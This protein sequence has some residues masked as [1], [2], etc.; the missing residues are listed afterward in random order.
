MTITDLPTQQVPLHVVRYGGMSEYLRFL[1]CIFTETVGYELTADNARINVKTPFAQLA[2]WD[3]P[4]CGTVRHDVVAA[5]LDKENAPSATRQL[6]R[7]ARQHQLFKLVMR[8]GGF[9]YRRHVFIWTDSPQQH[10]E[11]ASLA[12]DLGA[13][14]RRGNSSIRA[15][16]SI[17]RLNGR[18]LPDNPATYERDVEFILNNCYEPKWTPVGAPRSVAPIRRTSRAP[19]RADRGTPLGP[20]AQVLAQDGIQGSEGAF[21]LALSMYSGGRDRDEFLRTLQYMERHGKLRT[22]NPKHRG[23]YLK[24]WVRRI[25]VKVE[26]VA[27]TTKPV[28][29]VRSEQIAALADWAAARSWTGATGANTE[30]VWAA[31]VLRAAKLSSHTADGSVQVTAG[32]ASIATDAGVGLRAASTGLRQLQQLGVLRVLAKGGVRYDIGEDG[33]LQAQH[34][35]T[36]YALSV[37]VAPVD[38]YRADV[39]LRLPWGHDLFTY[40]GLGKRGLQMYRYLLLGGSTDDRQAAQDLGWHRLT[41]AR[42]RR[43]LTQAR[44]ISRRGMV[45][46]LQ[47]L[48]QQ[49]LQDQARRL[50][51]HGTI[52]RRIESWT[53][54]NQDAAHRMMD[55][56]AAWFR[57]HRRTL[58]SA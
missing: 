25:W 39:W 56:A 11:L 42:Y 28:G 29:S 53:Q 35:A 6:E 31:L 1:R 33:E 17:H 57:Q 24:S 54:R 58:S 46:A 18:S 52:K 20:T 41:V 32:V 4:F 37:P 43:K 40:R 45:T 12:S 34:L 36:I 47:D 9:N 23:R 15:P 7:Y 14:V 10:H 27:H 30:A 26:R 21:R 16:H 44:L 13:D 38:S 48:D 8:S 2:T 51:V 19:R 5:D 55:G 22:N 50:K 3:V 49:T